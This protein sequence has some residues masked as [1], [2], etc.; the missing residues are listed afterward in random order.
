MADKTQPDEFGVTDPGVAA[1]GMP[2]EPPKLTDPSQ[3]T[4]LA[5]GTEFIDPTGKKR[6]KPYDLK[7][8]EPA[9]WAEAL[10]SVPDGA[11]FV[12]PQGNLRDKPVYEPLDFGDQI[13]VDLTLYDPKAFAFPWHDTVIF[14][15]LADWTEAPATF[16]ECVST[17]NVYMDK[18]GTLR[19]RVVGDPNYLD[20]SDPRPWATAFARGEAAASKAAG[21]DPK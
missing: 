10:R 7:G 12:D 21:K 17:N 19:E 18:D 6:V 14:H 4:A 3:V 15:K 13:L 1:A 2:V 5:P 11:P 20:I 9:K 16:S 8:L